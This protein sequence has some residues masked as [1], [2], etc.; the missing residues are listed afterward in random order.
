MA[1]KDFFVRIRADL[2]DARRKIGRFGSYVDS[3]LGKAV[4]SVVNLKNAFLALG[5]SLLVRSV[6][7]SID[8]YRLLESQI[9]LVTNSE[10]ELKKTETD[11]FKLSQQTRS[12]YE[13]T[14]KLYARAA[15]NTRDLGLN[16][17]TLL[18]LTKA[19]NQSIQIGGQTTAEAANGVIQFSQAM[20]AGILRGQDFRSVMENMPRLARAIADGMGIT[21]GKLRELANNGELD[22]QR[23][24]AAILKEKD[25]LDQ[26]FSKLAPTI[27]QKLL[28]IR[29]AFER[30]LS[31]TNVDD[32][33]GSL[34]EFKNLIDD[35]ATL[36]SI[37]AFG[38]AI[39]RSVTFAV[40]AIAK[41]T[42]GVQSLSEDIARFVTG[43]SGGQ[44]FNLSHDELLKKR[45]E[46]LDQ[47]GKKE[48]YLKTHGYDFGGVKRDI[49][50]ANKAL[51]DQLRQVELLLKF[52]KQLSAEEE[53][54]A[55]RGL[56]GE[57]LGVIPKKR[58]AQ[59]G[60]APAVVG[61]ATASSKAKQ[62]QD[63]YQKV[64]QDLQRQLALFDDNTKAAAVLYETQKGGLQ[65]L[66]AAQKE[67]LITLAKELDVKEKLQQK[68]QA[69]QQETKQRQADLKA[70][71]NSLGTET[72]LEQQEYEK[73]IALLAESL[74]RKEISQQEYNNLIEKEQE[75]HQNKLEEISKNSNDGMTQYAIQAARDIQSAF[76]NFFFDAMEGKFDDLVGSFKKTLDRMVANL[77][78]SQL[79]N[80]LLGDFGKTGK[81][82]GLA[83]KAANYIFGGGKAIGGGV[84]K[85]TAV[86]VNERGGEFLYLGDRSGTIMPANQVLNK[87]GGSGRPI[88]VNMHIQTPDVNSF[89]KSQ[90]QLSTDAGILIQRALKRNT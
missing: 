34:D 83:G 90:G 70:L 77:L 59:P 86:R 21:I 27:G 31:H 61:S 37:T 38:A 24:I 6:T 3:R 82:G 23:V 72:E 29:N 65:D 53:K 20:A 58:Q 32:L 88:N 19:T 11:L 44:F 10:E 84:G 26:E 18:E 64:Q 80:F 12:D 79:L 50:E 13:S 40:N 73:R 30:D 17:K 81:L 2:S 54:R 8:K 15:R 52:T 47:I 48:A 7:S 16:Q 55:V 51:K 69:R 36:Q 76:S 67:Q 35:P 66:S 33:I 43:S 1:V 56:N 75:A 14:V 71:E 45:A 22:I 68:E 9:R 57:L 42:K 28:Q 5:A 78:A 60:A 25:K 49:E 39:V 74:S 63:D 4:N 62:A 89:R 41:L 87:M 85:N 46:L